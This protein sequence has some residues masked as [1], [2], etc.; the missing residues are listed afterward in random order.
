MRTSWI[1]LG[2]IIPGLG[3]QGEEFKLYLKFNGEE[4]KE[5]GEE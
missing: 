1:R 2:Y 4:L 5:T 3:G